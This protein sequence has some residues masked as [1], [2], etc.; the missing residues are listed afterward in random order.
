M[1]GPTGYSESRSRDAAIMVD[2]PCKK[3][4]FNLIGL[5][6][7]GICPECGTSFKPKPLRS[8]FHLGDAPESYISTVQLGLAMLVGSFV[9][10]ALGPILGGAI[11]AVVG[12]PLLALGV[13]GWAGGVHIVT[14]PRPCK[15][16]ETTDPVLDSFKY[17][18]ILRLVHLAPAAAA[19]LLGMGSIAPSFL[20]TGLAL[21]GIVAA[22]IAVGGIVPLA[23][24]L[25]G[26]AHWAAYDKAAFRFYSSAVGM[27]AFGLFAAFGALL[28]VLG[29]STGMQWFAFWAA[30]VAMVFAVIFAFATTQLLTAFG[31]AIKN[32]RYHAG[33]ADRVAEKIATR[34]K[35]PG[36]CHDMACRKCRFDLEGLPHG[37]HCPECGHSYADITPLPI[38]RPSDSL[39]PTE[40]P[41][42]VPGH[43]LPD[44]NAKPFRQQRGPNVVEQS[45][46][47]N[48][49]DLDPDS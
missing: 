46:E 44:T 33:A 16:E 22:A 43:P 8:N 18:T 39:K 14:T 15:P 30:A 17:R 7:T 27:T 28:S 47:S 21:L 23:I 4:S 48:P 40:L 31:W 32:Q 2:T 12:V 24:Y 19:V 38:R 6:R 10:M 37:G 11:H 1:T 34:L 26:L 41:I 42:P 29:I 35:G 20:G 3:C 45:G 5:P 9:C 36:L 13:L 25:G 49:I